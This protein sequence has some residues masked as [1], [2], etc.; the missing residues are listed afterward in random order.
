MH[1]VAIIIAAVIVTALILLIFVI[2]PPNISLDPPTADIGTDFYVTAYFLK[3]SETVF[4]NVIYD[5]ENRTVQSQQYKVNPFGV[6]SFS[7]LTPDFDAGEYKLVIISS[8]GEYV[9]N[10]K[11]SERFSIK[12]PNVPMYLPQPSGDILI[13]PIEG[14][15]GTTFKI[16]AKSL[17]PHTI[18]TVKAECC[19]N[20]VCTD[21]KTL[22]IRKG[23]QEMTNAD[24][25]LITLISTDNSWPDGYS[26]YVSV[27]DYRNT[28]SGYFNIGS[29]PLC[30]CTGL[31]ECGYRGCCAPNFT[32]PSL[33][34][35]AVTLCHE[36][37]VGL[38]PV[39]VIWINFWNT[40][41][42]GCAEYMKIIQH[43]KD[44]WNT[45]E[46]KIYSINCGEDPVTVAK[47]LT[48]RGYNFFNDSSYP[49]LFDVDK[50]VK[51]RYQPSGDP[52]HYF[53]DQKGIIRV[54]KFGYRSINT[55]E[56]VRAI[57]S[58]IIG[59]K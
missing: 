27:A 25:K 6:L 33:S 39:P 7:I 28:V 22:Y 8:R 37:N 52:P 45:G 31:Y 11:V 35:E 15:P 19:L 42:P 4:V 1:S 14:K 26:Y 17:R 34:G 54:V 12:Q 50:S 51:G 58:E 16:T 57:V 46:L 47:F 13:E 21:N 10:F 49:V 2:L 30:S 40:S 20:K 53:I 44:T 56:E 38:A 48:D 9:R 55:E 41:C 36:Y 23:E 3:P 43:I 18:V 5:A 24:G 32:L 29:Y 59:R